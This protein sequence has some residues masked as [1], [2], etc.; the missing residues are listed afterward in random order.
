MRAIRGW[1]WARKRARSALA[2]GSAIG[3]F[4]AQRVDVHA[5]DLELVV[6]VRAGGKAGGADVADHLALL[7]RAASLHAFGEALHVAV[8]RAVGIA[9]LEDRRCCRS[10]HGDR[11]AT[12]CHHRPP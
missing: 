1:L 4:L 6:Q 7:D 2:I 8:Q 12:L 10:R 3:S 11:P 5:I 9:V